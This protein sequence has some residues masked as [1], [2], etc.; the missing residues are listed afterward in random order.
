[1]SDNVEHTLSDDALFLKDFLGDKADTITEVMADHDFGVPVW[2]VAARDGGGVPAFFKGITDWDELRS[3]LEELTDEELDELTE[4]PG[5]ILSAAEMKI[6][7]DFQVW[8]ETGEE[9]SPEIDTYYQKGFGDYYSHAWMSD[10]RHTLE[11]VKGIATFR[12]VAVVTIADSDIDYDSKEKSDGHPICISDISRLVERVYDKPDMTLGFQTRITRVITDSLRK[13]AEQFIGKGLLVQ[14]TSSFMVALKKTK[15]WPQIKT[16]LDN[17][18]N[19][20]VIT[21]NDLKLEGRVKGLSPKENGWKPGTAIWTDCNV[22]VINKPANNNRANM[23]PQSRAFWTTR[24][25]DEMF[26]LLDK[27]EMYNRARACFGSFENRNVTHGTIDVSQQSGVRA[28]AQGGVYP[29]QIFS[30]EIERADGDIF[31]TRD[32]YSEALVRAQTD[33]NTW[34]FRRYAIRTYMRAVPEM[35]KCCVLVASGFLTRLGKNMETCEHIIFGR[36]PD[37]NQRGQATIERWETPE[38]LVAEG[39]KVPESTPWYRAKKAPVFSVYGIN[40]IHVEGYVFNLENMHGFHPEWAKYILMG[41]FDGDTAIACWFPEARERVFLGF[42]APFTKMTPESPDQSRTYRNML[43]NGIKNEES[44]KAIP[45][46]SA[47]L[48]GVIEDIMTSVAWGQIKIRGLWLKTEAGCRLSAYINAFI[49]TVKRQPKETNIFGIKVYNIDTFL[50]AIAIGLKWLQTRSSKPPVFD[51]WKQNGGSFFMPGRKG[52]QVLA[53]G[54]PRACLEG[55]SE[56]NKDASAREVS[57]AWIAKARGLE[58]GKRWTRSHCH[59]HALA[60]VFKCAHEK[61]EFLIADHDAMLDQLDRKIQMSPCYEDNKQ[62]NDALADNVQQSLDIVSG[63]IAKENKESGA[64][65]YLKSEVYAAVNAHLADELDSFESRHQFILR[66]LDTELHDTYARRTLQLTMTLATASFWEWFWSDLDTTPKDS[67]DVA[68]GSYLPAHI[69]RLT[70]D[71]LVSSHEAKAKAEADKK[72][73]NS[74]EGEYEFLSNMYP[75][76]IGDPDFLDVK[77]KTVEAAYHA[78]KTGSKK[79]RKK[80]SKMSPQ[81]ARKFGEK[82]QVS[83]RWSLGAINLMDILLTDKFLDEDLAEK[84]KATGDSKLINGNKFGDK[85][86]GVCNGHGQNELGELLMALREEL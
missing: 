41:D 49:D 63:D 27:D 58:K 76:E 35:N 33:F 45:I 72:N 1:M 60:E 66:C 20:I 59:R 79:I 71:D 68:V 77:Y 7:N 22:T 47:A 70:V 10:Q 54:N 18:A 82:M 69:V 81:A 40:C 73:I 42:E 12:D 6:G 48:N 65:K 30:Q 55:G 14:S 26:K 50:M 36:S 38:L 62:W 84:L 25:Q 61:Y 8:T 52:Y 23:G 2:E 19:V 64:V 43:I 80:I 17:D 13:K 44:A 28:L 34:D 11:D 39:I 67:P 3:D 56:E 29:E 83:D 5:Y 32:E 85:F 46:C 78:M 74:F 4:G 21:E 9:G 86:W 75:C 15:V 57:D 51:G 24:Q 37:I 16:L 53:I 31:E